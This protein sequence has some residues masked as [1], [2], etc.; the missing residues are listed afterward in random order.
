MGAFGELLK[1]YWGHNPSPQV[2]T[3]PKKKTKVE[4]KYEE[5][6]KEFEESACFGLKERKF[7][8]ERMGNHH[9]RY[10]FNKFMYFNDWLVFTKNGKYHYLD[11]ISK[12]NKIVVD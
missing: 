12:I 5:Q 4:L 9:K 1:V 7:L 6:R 10:S 2:R 3:K 8:V 11:V